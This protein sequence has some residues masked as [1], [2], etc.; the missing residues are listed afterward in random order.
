MNRITMTLKE[1]IIKLFKDQ[2]ELSDREIFLLLSK[3]M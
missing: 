3:W 2:L 1:R